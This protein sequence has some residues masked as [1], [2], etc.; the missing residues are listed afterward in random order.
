MSIPIKVTD[1]IL[2]IDLLR[3]DPLVCANQYEF[4][5]TFDAEWESITQR[6]ARIRFGGQYY[7]IPFTGT[8]FTANTPAGV[9]MIEIGIYGGTV[10]TSVKRVPLLGSVLDSQGQMVEFDSELYDQWDAAVTALLTDDALDGTSAHPVANSVITPML[11]DAV[12]KTGG[13]V[14]TITNDVAVTGKLDAMALKVVASYNSSVTGNRF[15]RIYRFVRPSGAKWH[16]TLKMVRRD[17]EGYDIITLQGTYANG[18]VGDC[19]MGV[20]TSWNDKQPFSMTYDAS[21]DRF[22]V[23]FKASG[24]SVRPIDVILVDGSN[25]DGVIQPAM[26]GS[27]GS[28][29]SRTGTEVASAVPTAMNYSLA[30]V[31]GKSSYS[32]TPWH[33]VAYTP[34]QAT[35]GVGRA[36]L[37]FVS[38]NNPALVEMFGIFHVY[39]RTT[40]TANLCMRWIAGYG[41]D[42]SNWAIVHRD[43]NVEIWYKQTAQYGVTETVELTGWGSNST[44]V[45]WTIDSADEQET[46]AALPSGEGIYSAESVVS[47]LTAPASLSMMSPSAL[48]G[49]ALDAP[50][51]QT[52]GDGDRGQEEEQR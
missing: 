32:S 42:P 43:G 28:A 29:T 8:T 9:P 39:Q 13:T 20:M 52:D 14:Q 23:Y 37:F 27:I 17:R 3:V 31:L 5:V 47:P 35:S 6:Y 51:A 18:E 45:Q 34:Y 12:Y 15:L 30:P 49:M 48:Q 41:I 1:R 2:E 10:A 16:I 50:D 24:T 40:A 44:F 26:V 4:A 7:E 11:Q 19:A 22:D 46:A 25:D 38:T 21:N 36:G 33:R